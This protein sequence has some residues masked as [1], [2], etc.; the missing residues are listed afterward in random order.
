MQ[1]N[2]TSCTY[3]NIGNFLKKIPRKWTFLCMHAM[4]IKTIN[5]FAVTYFALWQTLSVRFSSN[6]LCEHPTR[7]ATAKLKHGMELFCF[8]SLPLFLLFGG[9]GWK[10]P[11]LPS[12]GKKENHHFGNELHH[13]TLNSREFPR[14]HKCS[15]RA[16]STAAAAPY[17]WHYKKPRNFIN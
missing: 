10:V 17:M 11:A 6:A 3:D 4:R 12:L 7:L 14:V 8:L 5:P 16:K 2:N 1:L 13:L 15:A 9:F